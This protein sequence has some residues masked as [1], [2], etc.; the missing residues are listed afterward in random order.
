M[1]RAQWNE[2]CGSGVCRGVAARRPFTLIELLVVMALIMFLMGLLVAG[3]VVVNDKIGRTQ[4]K[5]FVKEVSLALENYKR[6][7]GYYPPSGNFRER[8]RDYDSL[9]VTRDDNAIDFT[10]FLPGFEKMVSEGV[11]KEV[12][13]NRYQLCDPYGVRVYYQA[14]GIHNRTSFDLCSAGPDGDIGG[15]T[16]SEEKEA[17]ADN[18]NNWDQ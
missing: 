3:M 6:K 11:L 2:R 1:L 14:P 10:D 7:T 15:D 18:I 9:V 17:E 5:A 8:V 4:C 12:S 16:S 13:S